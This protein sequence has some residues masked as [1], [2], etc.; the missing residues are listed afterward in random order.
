MLYQFICVLT[1]FVLRLFWASALFD[2]WPASN[3][4]RLSKTKKKKNVKYSLH[5]YLLTVLQDVSTQN[6]IDF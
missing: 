2:L 4:D 6:D 5:K 3:A 1:S